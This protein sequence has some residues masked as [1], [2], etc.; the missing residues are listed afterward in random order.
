MPNSAV[1]HSS[2]DGIHQALSAGTERPGSPAVVTLPRK[3]LPGVR[4]FDLTSTFS[5][6]PGSAVTHALII[7]QIFIEHLLGGRHHSQS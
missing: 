6:L 3:M 4:C 1:N 2:G 5:H 7:K